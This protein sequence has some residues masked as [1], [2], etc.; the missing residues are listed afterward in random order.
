MNLIQTAPL[1]LLVLVFGILAA[2]AVEDFFRRRISNI[3]CAAALVSALVAMGFAGFS[4]DL[5]QN[6]AVFLVLLGAGTLL[7]AAKW[8]GGGDVKLLAALGLWVDIDAGIWLLAT[9]LLAGGILA[10]VYILVRVARGQP[11]S[12][13]YQSKGIP[14]GIAIAVGAALIF[15]GQ[16]GLF[17][18]GPVN[19]LDIRTLD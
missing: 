7:F 12:K 15:A 18:S 4:F 6:V 17:K 13:K 1:W 8:M 19:P 2:A 5:W 3:T 11:F 16:Y 14:Y 10:A 9:I